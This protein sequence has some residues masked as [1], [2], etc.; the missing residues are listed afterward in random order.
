MSTN[1]AGPQNE[2]MPKIRKFQTCPIMPNLSTIKCYI[3]NILNKKVD[4][5]QAKR[6]ENRR[7]AIAEL[8]G[9]TLRHHTPIYYTNI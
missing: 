1:K 2:N 6:I 8:P 5:R 9:A 4:R 3:C 7:P